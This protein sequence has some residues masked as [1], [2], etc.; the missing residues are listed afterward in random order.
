MPLAEAGPVVRL[1]NP[2]WFCALQAAGTHA[3]QLLQ[4]DAAGATQL[5]VEHYDEVPPRD[6]MSSI[7]V[8][9]QRLTG[10]DQLTLCNICI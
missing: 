3:V 5:F 4:I 6:V 1:L 9:I 7:Q 10:I 2:C 8:D